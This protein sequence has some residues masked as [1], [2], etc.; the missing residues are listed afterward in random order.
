MS[1]KHARVRTAW[2]E[3][4]LNHGPNMT[5]MVDVVM[6]ILVFFMATASVLGPEWY[7]KSSI[8]HTAPAGTITPDQNKIEQI[9]LSLSVRDRTHTVVTGGGLTRATL[10]AAFEML[11]QKR[12]GTD[13]NNLVVLLAPDPD[14]PYQ[15]LVALHETC[16]R[17][18]IGKV[19]IQE[20]K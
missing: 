16:E 13:P 4:Q 19:G 2:N 10:P 20:A 1:K 9:R 15:D 18:G 17:L 11:R 14:V 12:V 8:P 6:V 5:P 7:L 3:Y